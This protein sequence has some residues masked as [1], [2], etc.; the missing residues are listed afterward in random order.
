M[1]T[2]PAADGN[3]GE[4]ARAPGDGRDLEF[5]AREFGHMLGQQLAD[6]NGIV[7]PSAVRPRTRVFDPLQQGGLV[8]AG[9]C[10]DHA[11]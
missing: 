2:E 4:L 5:P 9:R 7:R 3:L 6:E 8:A 10:W 11:F 1:E